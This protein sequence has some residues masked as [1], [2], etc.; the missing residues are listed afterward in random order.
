MFAINGIIFVDSYEDLKPGA[1]IDVV[2]DYEESKKIEE[3][4]DEA[5]W[6]L[7]KEVPFE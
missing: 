3:A 5:L 4:I 6:E 7:I 2:S 1:M